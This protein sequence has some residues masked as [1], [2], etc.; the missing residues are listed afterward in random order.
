MHAK[1]TIQRLRERTEVESGF[2]L[3]ELLI[4]ITI[5]GILAAIVVFAV[6]TTNSQA[7][8]SACQTDVKTVQTGVEA[9]AAQHNGS[10]PATLTALLSKDSSGG[11]WLRGP[12][13]ADIDSASYSSTDGTVYGTT[14]NQAPAGG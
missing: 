10:Y 8:T 9:Y 5:L 4:V 14:C 12:I 7:K 3:I 11:P 13:P 6:G 2:T 1:T